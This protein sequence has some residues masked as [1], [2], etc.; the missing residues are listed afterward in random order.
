MPDTA[1][2][3]YETL[4]M[5]EDPQ[6]DTICYFACNIC[7]RRL[8]DGPCPDHAPLDVPGLQL[9]ECDA[10]RR[11]ACT[12]VL[13]GDNYGVP[14]MYCA[15][16][17]LNERLKY[18]D[19]CRHWGWR[20]TRL[21]KKLADRAYALGIVGGYGI[22]HGGGQYDHHGCAHGFRW[23]G[24]RNYVLGWPTWKWSCLFRK[25]HWPATFV[26]LDA[27]TKC[28]PCPTCGGTGPECLHACS[29][30]RETSS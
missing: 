8:D 18:L 28:Y 20:R 23:R 11:H 13:A 24:K 16:D 12:W 6:G 3:Y 19:R 9:A 10:K 22:S 5:D 15:Y 30:R 29:N 14:C 21:F 25:R 27:C 26:G 1:T 4:V 2:A 17:T 7:E